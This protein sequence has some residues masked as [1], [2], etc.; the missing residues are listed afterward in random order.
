M[1]AELQAII[2]AQAE[3]LAEYETVISDATELLGHSGSEHVDLRDAIGQIERL[4]AGED[5]DATNLEGLAED[6]RVVLR[7]CKR[8]SKTLADALA[9]CKECHS[10]S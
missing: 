7:A 5:L 8:A 6:I 9:Q 1:S 4:L 3:R 2:Q 10:P